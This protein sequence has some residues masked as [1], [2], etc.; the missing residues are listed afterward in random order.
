MQNERNEREIMVGLNKMTNKTEQE[1]ATI[2]RADKYFQRSEELL[3]ELRNVTAFDSGKQ[4]VNIDKDKKDSRGI[5][6]SKTLT[7]INE[8]IRLRNEKKV[9]IRTIIPMLHSGVWVDGQISCRN[10]DILHFKTQIRSMQLSKFKLGC[11]ANLHEVSNLFKKHPQKMDIVEK[12][13][14]KISPNDEEE[15][16][17]DDYIIIKLKQPTTIALKE[18]S[19]YKRDTEFKFYIINAIIIS[20]KGDVTFGRY[21]EVNEMLSHAFKERDIY[22]IDDY[23]YNL[24]FTKFKD[25]IEIATKEYYETLTKEKEL[26]EKD[27]SEI[28][29]IGQDYL[30]LAQIEG[31]NK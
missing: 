9:L 23:A 14:D 26:L 24:L 27:I 29:E 13:L 18:I 3:I 31:N 4:T 16:S 12:I 15:F 11:Y 5:L 1:K 21:K 8:I 6:K 28:K 7:V 30:L 22:N 25:E 19:Y 2:E 20:K 10:K 17:K